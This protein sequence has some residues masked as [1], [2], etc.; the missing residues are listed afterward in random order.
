MGKITRRALLLGGAGLG[1]SGGVMGLSWVR[2]SNRYEDLVNRTWQP[3]EPVGQAFPNSHERLVAY[4]CMAANAHNTQPWKFSVFE[5]RIHI[6]PDFNRATPVVDPEHRHL[7]ASLGCAAENLSVAAQAS[8]FSAPVTFQDDGCTVHLIGDEKAASRSNPRFEAIPNRQCVRAIYDGRALSDADLQG[9]REALDDEE[10]S[11][12]LVTNRAEIDQL[13]DLILSANSVQLKNQAF[14]NELKAWIRF[15][16][17]EAAE[18]RDGLYAPASGNPAVPGWL[19]RRIFDLVVSAD[20]ENAK[21]AEQIASSA[22]LVVLAAHRDD[23][24]G[25]MQ[26]GQ[27]CQRFALE[28]TARGVRYAFLNQPI[29]VAEMLPELQ[30]MLRTDLRPNL[31]MRFGYGPTLPRSL[32]R[33]AEDVITRSG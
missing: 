20:G 32:R 7:F 18:T 25:W 17:R 11:A 23:P 4:A 33:S 27:S 3:V 1:V 26:A 13:R 6:A 8:G 2:G 12:F 22:G 30:A 10:V 19:G 21:Y 16:G 9:L 28:A 29:E 31:L 15:S 24:I 14:R 5:D